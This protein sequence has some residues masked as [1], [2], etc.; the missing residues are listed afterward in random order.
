ML[1]KAT[2]L[3]G[4]EVDKVH[5][6]KASMMSRGFPGY[7]QD[8]PGR[9]EAAGGN[10]Q[11]GVCQ[12]RELMA[13]EGRGPRQETVQQR[14][15]SLAGRA[16]T[17]PPPVPGAR[18]SACP[19]P[20]TRC[21]APGTR[22]T[23]RPR[24]VVPPR[25][26]GSRA[27]ATASSG[28]ASPPASSCELVGPRRDRAR[29]QRGPASDALRAATLTHGKRPG[30]GHPPKGPGTPLGK[31]SGA[32]GGGRAPPPATLIL[33][34]NGERHGSTRSRTA[35]HRFRLRASR[36]HVPCRR[37]LRFPATPDPA[38]VHRPA[39]PWT[40]ER[41]MASTPVSAVV[42]A[43]P[44]QAWKPIAGFD[45]LP[46]RLPCIARAHRSRP[47]G[48]AGSPTRA[49]RPSLN[50]RWTSMRRSGTTV[51]RSSRRPPGRRPPRD[52]SRLPGGRERER[53][54]GPVVRPVHARRGQR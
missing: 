31:R 43:P 8:V 27:S 1:S 16:G 7:G 53:R 18:R 52:T 26:R 42:P 32:A 36:Q 30:T 38:C 46:D 48:C 17:P 15:W 23:A 22:D 37:R 5:V 21:P 33:P 41:S 25:R 13:G 40:Q 28:T 24:P 9:T 11:D 35:P 47:A 54:R 4:G 19:A 51:T 10:R 12:P 2:Y 49:A 29:E 20:G 45:S 50:V 39:E 14:R 44:D 3:C 6:R 34:A